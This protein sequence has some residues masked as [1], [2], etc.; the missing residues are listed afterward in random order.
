MLS[1]NTIN[2]KPSLQKKKKKRLKGKLKSS[3]IYGATFLRLTFSCPYPISKEVIGKLY[4]QSLYYESNI[5]HF[6]NR[7]FN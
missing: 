3:S 6:L 1:E 4:F 5:F 7:T 2:E